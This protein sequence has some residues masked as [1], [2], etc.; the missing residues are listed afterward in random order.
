MSSRLEGKVAI[1]TGVSRGTGEQTARLFVEEGARVVIADV[2]EDEGRAVAEDL[3]DAAQFCRLDVTDEASWAETLG[4]TQAWFGA[5]TILVN[6]AGLLHI[7]SL[8]ETS[9]ADVERLCRANALG[10]FL[11]T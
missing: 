1:I 10:P 5:P 6:N 11:W 8:V 4:S 2:L 7:Q 3:K 9:A